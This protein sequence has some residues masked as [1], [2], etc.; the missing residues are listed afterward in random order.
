MCD[1][2][3]V[4]VSGYRAGKRRGSAV[5]KRLTDCG[6]LARPRSFHAELK[7]GYGSPSMVRELRA[8][9]FSAKNIPTERMMC[10]IDIRT[11]HKRRYKVTTD[12]KHRLPITNNLFAR[13]VAPKAPH[14]IWTSDILYLSAGGGW[15]YVVI[16]LNLFSHWI[17]GWSLKPRM[18]ADIVTGALTMA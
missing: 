11:C 17:V 6:M 7:G 10:N 9:S 18:A 2:L 12:S 16:V 5:R 8:R 1:V 4:S 15:L 3:K 14:Q 13:N